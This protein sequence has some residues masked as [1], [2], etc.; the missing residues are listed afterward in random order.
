MNNSPVMDFDVIIVGAGIAGSALACA[1]ANKN[2]TL[3][4]ALIEAQPLNMPEEIS[5]ESVRDYDARVSA[6]TVAS[7]QLLEEFGLWEGIK[8]KRISPYAH[9][10]VWDAEGTGFISFD[11][12]EIN[13][14]ALGHIVENRLVTAALHQRIENC[15]NIHCLCP[16]KVTDLQQQQLILDDQRCLRAPLIVAA[17]GAQS[18]IRQL[19]GFATR[20][21]DYEHH[22][23]VAT[24]ETELTHQHTAW[25][26]FLPQGP[27][28]FLPLHSAANNTSSIVWS[29][30][31]EYAE[32][33]MAMSE[34]EFK[35]ELS[36]AFEH[37]LGEILN[38]GQ[39]FAFPL[40]QRHA[41]DYVKPGLALIADAAHTVHPLAGQGINLGL[42][43]VA[44]LAKELLRAQQRGLPLGDL[45]V[46]KRYQR[47]RKGSNLA[48]MAA[49]EGFKR[50]FAEPALPVRWARNSGMRWLDG[51]P[52]LKHKIIRQAM[53]L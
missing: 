42:L 51:M 14:P 39:R 38:V 44:V 33:L 23:I 30:T 8:E 10:H 47:R 20:E 31:P 32:S 24:V 17:D 34:G 11:A 9:M 48:M 2:N 46:L 19:A 5:G 43:D 37:R 52:P 22:A 50:L 16:A 21:W 28:A 15:D 18:K 13:Q 53:G 36:S 6:L 27:L 4:I 41:Q 7:Q 29:A 45:G 26:R 12:A 1:L 3:N 40:R 25:Q 35:L 49:M